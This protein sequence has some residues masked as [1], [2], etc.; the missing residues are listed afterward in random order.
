MGIDILALLTAILQPGLAGYALR[1]H[2]VFGSRRVGWWVFY[3]FLGLGLLQIVHLLHSGGLAVSLSDLFISMLLLAGMIHAEAFC[4]SGVQLERR[5][6]TLAAELEKLRAQTEAL[7]ST[8]ASL[9]QRAVQ[10]EQEQAGLRASEQQFRL[11]FMENP[12]PMWVFD[13]RSLRLLAFNK[14]ALRQYGLNPAEL[15]ARTARDLCAA[16]D[17]PAFQLDC[18][19]PSSAGDAPKLWRHRRKDGSRL[20]VEVRT[21][22]LLYD[23]CPARLNVAH[24]VG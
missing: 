3:T 13:L 9:V 11:A 15:P 21:L 10:H 17:V 2:R 1:L 6:Q 23:Q 20:R 14:A 18:S 16:E 24:V 12:Q 5:E 8:N 4:A 22:D 7:N 19:R